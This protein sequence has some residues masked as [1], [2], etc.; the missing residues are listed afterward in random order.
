M[1]E[2]EETKEKN[3]GH[4]MYYPYPMYYN[5]DGGSRKT[6]TET[7]DSSSNNGGIS[8][9]GTV[10][11]S[12]G[13]MYYSGRIHDDMIKSK[14]SHGQQMSPT[15]YTEREFPHAFDDPREGRSYRSRRTYMESKEAHQDKTSQMKELEKYAQE[16]TQD[17]IEMVEGSSPE[18][19]QY[20]SK[21]VAALANKITQLNNG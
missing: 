19:R 14:M 17:I 11:G 16:L 2:A 20:L 9:N 3:P 4:P 7:S 5:G 15:E 18:E 6:V 12:D 1:E 8:G 10:N 21:K 13:R